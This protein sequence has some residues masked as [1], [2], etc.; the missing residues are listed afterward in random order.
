M[1][2]PGISGAFILVLMG[3]YSTV[4]KAISDFDLKTIVIFGLGAVHRII[5]LFKVMLKWLFDRHR[6]IVLAILTGFITGSLNKIWPW[7]KVIETKMI[8]GK[9]KII[10]EISVLPWNY[11]GEPLLTYAILL[12]IAGFGLIFGLEYFSNR[13][14]SN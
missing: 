6:N 9:E 1:I 13:T 11:E 8:N 7:K 2:L 5:E 12:A 14:S 4:T 3:A 10:N